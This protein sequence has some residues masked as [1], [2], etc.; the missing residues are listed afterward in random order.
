MSS[1]RLCRFTFVSNQFEKTL[2]IAHDKRTE[3][4]KENQRYAKCPVIKNRRTILPIHQEKFTSY[5]SNSGK[6]EFADDR[7]DREYAGSFFARN[8][9]RLQA[10]NC[11]DAD[12]NEYQPP[13]VK[14]GKLG[15]HDYES[16]RR[17]RHAEQASKH[18]NPLQAT[19]T[20]PPTENMNAPR[21]NVS[22][23][24]RQKNCHVCANEYSIRFRV[25]VSSLILPLSSAATT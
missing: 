10:P 9:S 18:P 6:E 14:K 20:Q 16:E 24:R 25:L 22:Q 8:P 21:Q 15:E 3:D 5:C 19:L 13:F 1:T 17:Q 12:S 7:P 4:G 11:N 2:R 23:N